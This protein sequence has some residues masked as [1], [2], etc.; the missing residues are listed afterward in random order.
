MNLSFVK[1]F[2]LQSSIEKRE[3]LVIKPQRGTDTEENVTVSRGEH[4][5]QCTGSL[6]SN[7][8]KFNS[9]MDP[10]NDCETRQENVDLN[11]NPELQSI[12]SALLLRWMVESRVKDRNRV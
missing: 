10:I 12:K 1:L 6:R 7:Q 5:L 4:R 2:A 9:T 3:P 8:H 11:L